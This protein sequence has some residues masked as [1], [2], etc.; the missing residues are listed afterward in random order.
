M[1][2]GSEFGLLLSDLWSDLRD[3]NVVWQVGVLA[4]CLGLA[5]L[6]SYLVQRRRPH[7][8]PTAT[9]AAQFGQRGLRR[10]A[11]P[12]SA[13]VLVLMARPLLVQW[14]HVNL[15]SLAVPLLL[16][17]AVIRSVFFV[18]RL[19]F[20]GPWLASFERTFAAFAWGLVALYITGLVPDLI[21]L[22]ESISFTVGKQHLDLWMILQGIAT[23][24]A[25]LLLAL[26][27]GGTVEGRLMTAPGLDSNLRIVFA[28]LAKAVLIVI[29]VLIALPVVGLDL[30]TLSVFGGALGVGLGFGLQKIAANYVSG[31]IILLDR[32]IRI[33]DLISV[34]QDR[35]QV[36]RITTRYTVIRGMT[37]IEAIVPNEVLVG[38]VVQNE[39]YTDTKVRLTLP[40]Q[41]AYGT[42]L[43]R[44]MAIMV[45]ATA[46]QQRILSEPGPKAFV[47]AFADSGIN[48]ELGFWVGDPEEGT[49]QLRSDINLA[50][51]R[52]FQ[53]AGI[54]IPFPQR[55]VRIIDRQ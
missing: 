9:R 17:M 49:L 51:W 36:S 19:S 15:L 37:G 42:D 21:A 14:H 22:L 11:F 29:A 46:A 23:V 39:S 35:G 10:V 13:L 25:T 16:S 40:V 12:L 18:L 41:V 26:W 28:R 20:S 31:F 34:G 44:A 7:A 24:L 8:D 54:E 6:F 5:W 1:S 45:E 32:S 43:E 53:S 27:V 4:L 48:L 38:S 50:I 55:E 33:G 47:V 52:A 2:G 30:T 3:P